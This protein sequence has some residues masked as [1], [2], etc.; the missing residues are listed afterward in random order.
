M[1][2]KKNI[3]RGREIIHYDYLMGLREELIEEFF[4]QHPNHEGQDF[5]P[6]DALTLPNSWGMS[7]LKYNHVNEKDNPDKQE[8]AQ[9]RMSL[10]KQYEEAKAKYPVAYSKIVDHWG[11]DCH[12]AA[13]LTMHPGTVLRRHTG[14]ENRDAKYIRIHIPLI[15][16]E[17][18]L[19]MEIFGEQVSWDDLFAFDNQK[20]HSAWNFTDKPRLIFL[21]DLARSACN[22][23]EGD[24]WDK[25]RDELDAPPFPKLYGDV[26]GCPE[27]TTNY[28]PPGKA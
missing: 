24:P 13:Y 26:G 25:Q 16:P 10:I 19:G 1:L 27:Y 4:K 2:P 6:T 5:W 15:I 14:D 18:D 11:D 17:G 23:P 28:T 21:L 8:T 3:Y 20:I 7:L 12:V 22:M 9:E